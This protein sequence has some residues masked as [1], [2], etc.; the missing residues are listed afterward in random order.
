MSTIRSGAS[1]G[2]HFERSCFRCNRDQATSGGDVSDRDTTNHSLLSPHASPVQGEGGR[3]R[4]RSS[5]VR[6]RARDFIPLAT[7]FSVLQGRVRRSVSIASIADR[8]RFPSRQH[9]TNKIV[10]EDE[11]EK[12]ER[13]RRAANDRRPTGFPVLARQYRY[14]IE[15]SAGVCNGSTAWSNGDA[16]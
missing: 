16:G 15:H 14:P 7:G 11:P 4:E 5:R 10:Q 2:G 6:S 1:G 3:G 13:E 12:F 8:I 9:G